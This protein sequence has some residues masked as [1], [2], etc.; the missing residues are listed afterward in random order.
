MDNQASG[1]DD[2]KSYY[3]SKGKSLGHELPPM[4]EIAR[5]LTQEDTKQTTVPSLCDKSPDFPD[6]L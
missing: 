3:C 5:R 2:Q 6:A 1:E 4:A